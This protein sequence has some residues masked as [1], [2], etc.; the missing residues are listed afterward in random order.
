MGIGDN[1]KIMRMYRNLTQN[2]LA[3]RMGISRQA[4]YMWESDRRR[5]NAENIKKL[6]KAL[7]VKVSDLLDIEWVDAEEWSK[8]SPGE[9]V[10]FNDKTG[11][12]SYKRAGSTRQAIEQQ[13][14]NNVE[15]LNLEGIGKVNDYSHE[16]VKSE[17]FKREDK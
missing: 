6:A 11:V 7:G 17:E 8:P 1:I 13:L 4:V 14:K 15:R 3:Q 2:E 5:P 10:E 16:L 12:T 9:I